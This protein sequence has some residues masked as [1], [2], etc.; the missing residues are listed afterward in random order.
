MPEKLITNQKFLY[1]LN[2]TSRDIT[3]KPKNMQDALLIH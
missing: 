1:I 2:I 3:T